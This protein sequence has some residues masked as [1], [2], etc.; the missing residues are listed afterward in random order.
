MTG[1]VRVRQYTRRAGTHRRI[2]YVLPRPKARRLGF[3]PGARVVKVSFNPDTIWPDKEGVGK[4][5]TVIETQQIY[6]ER[7][8]PYGGIRYHFKQRMESED[9]IFVKWDDEEQVSPEN[10]AYLRLIA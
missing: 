2:G 9:Y 5:G 7:I 10:I 3:I 6:S 8:V 4:T 1:P